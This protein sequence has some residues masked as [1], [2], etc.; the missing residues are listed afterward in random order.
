MGSKRVLLITYFF[1]PIFDVGMFRVLKFVKYLPSFG[2]QPIV[3]TVGN[4]SCNKLDWT[5]FE[6]VP[7]LQVI[8]TFQVEPSIRRLVKLKKDFEETFSFLTQEGKVNNRE[9]LI[10]RFKNWIIHNL[11]IPDSNVGW[12]PFGV[13][14]AVE[15]C[16]REKIDV[17]FS[18]APP[19]TAHAIGLITKKVSGFPWVADFR[20]PWSLAPQFNPYAS[21]LK[22]GADRW[23]ENLIY[24][25]ADQCVFVYED[26][27]RDTLREFSGLSADRCVFIPNGFDSE[28]FDYSIPADKSC[29]G[30]THAGRLI[31]GRS[32]G[33]FLKSV[34]KVLERKPELKDV[35][36]LKFAGEIDEENRSMLSEFPYPEIIRIHG[37]LSMKECNKMLCAS[38]LLLCIISAEE[39]RYGSTTSKIMNYI[40]SGRPILLISPPGPAAMFVTENRLGFHLNTEDPSGAPIR[41]MKIL[42]SELDGF[43]PNEEIRS[44]YERKAQTGQLARL[45]DEVSK[46]GGCG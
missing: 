43:I 35:L 18:T 31:H 40:G 10:K 24:K 14:R 39:N 28:D 32:L 19:L 16:K 4:A 26:Q 44:L 20:D 30:I 6:E 46:K 5:P 45:F 15:I 42:D 7:N 34:S 9:G 2:W 8:R 25:H 29:I 41:L 37:I 1:P 17:L 21:E 3:L 22:K 33:F 12:L 36:R 11:L 27:I 38:N 23:V 13:R